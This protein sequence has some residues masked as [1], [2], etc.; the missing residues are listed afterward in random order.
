VK[1]FVERMRRQFPIRPE[2]ESGFGEASTIAPPSD[3][4]FVKPAP[5]VADRANAPTRPAY[6]HVKGARFEFHVVQVSF[7]LSC[8][9]RILGQLRPLMSIAVT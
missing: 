7:D 1:E 5:H 3:N 9:I 8:G 6:D 4:A 2:N